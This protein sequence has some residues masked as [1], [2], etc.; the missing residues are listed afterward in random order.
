MR[1]SSGMTRS[2]RSVRPTRRELPAS[3]QTLRPFMG[4]QRTSTIK[5]GAIP[6]RSPAFRLLV[7]LLALS[8]AVLAERLVRPQRLGLSRRA[9]HHGGAA[10]HDDAAVRRRVAE[11]GSG[12]VA[13]EH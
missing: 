8:L 7:S 1:L 9:D 4:T 10:F 3:T 5:P 6:P 13:D 12:L 2:A 11:A